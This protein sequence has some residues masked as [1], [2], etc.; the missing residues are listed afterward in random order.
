MQYTLD[1]MYIY[2]IFFAH[3]VVFKILIHIFSVLGILLSA[4]RTAVIATAESDI[5]DATESDTN[6]IFILHLLDNSIIAGGQAASFWKAKLLFDGWGYQATGHNRIT[7]LVEARRLFS[8]CQDF[9][10]MSKKSEEYSDRISGL[11]EARE[12]NHYVENPSYLLALYVFGK[13]LRKQVSES[14][15]EV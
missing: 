14:F 3:I 15:K 6:G 11:L 10:F 1:R 4:G 9:N 7:Q 2:Y 12:N 13:I 8:Q 5:I